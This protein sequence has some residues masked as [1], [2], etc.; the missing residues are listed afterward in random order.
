MF[1][2]SS[3]VN[4]TPL[5]HADTSRDVLP[6]GVKGRSNAEAFSALETAVGWYEQ[7][8]ERCPT[9]LLL[10]KR[11]GDLAAKKKRCTMVERKISDYFAIKCPVSYTAWI[12]FGL[13]NN[14]VSERH[15]VPVDSVKRRSTV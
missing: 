14:R 7:Q 15:P 8:S 9:Q 3:Y 1:D 5:A 12:A 10:L 13:P 11:I 4:P 6:R 2:F